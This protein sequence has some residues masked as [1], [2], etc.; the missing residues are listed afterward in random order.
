MGIV[1]RDPEK[2]PADP[3]KPNIS[4]LRIRKEKSHFSRHA[5]ETMTKRE[6]FKVITFAPATLFV[7][8]ILGTLLTVNHSAPPR[9]CAATKTYSAFMS[10]I[11]AS[12]APGVIGTISRFSVSSLHTVTTILIL[13]TLFMVLCWTFQLPTFIRI[14]L[15]REDIEFNDL[16]SN[17]S[18]IA[19]ITP[20]GLAILLQHIGFIPAL[21]G[22]E[23][24]ALTTS[25]LPWIPDSW[26]RTGVS[27]VLFIASTFSLSILVSAINSALLD[28]N[29]RFPFNGPFIDYVNNS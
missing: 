11:T 13:L 24:P 5:S 20:I 8:F 26:F 18:F 1:F 6:T 17:Q 14:A 23:L 9:T 29:P 15:K 7:P 19:S 12:E 10:R 28:S 3:P 4:S 25:W 22:C 2:S 16:E 21:R 27:W